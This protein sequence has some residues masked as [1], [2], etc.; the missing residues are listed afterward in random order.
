MTG[1]WICL[2]YLTVTVTFCKACLCFSFLHHQFY[3]LMYVK[4]FTWMNEIQYS[5]ENQYG[6][7]ERGKDLAGHFSTFK[8]FWNVLRSFFNRLRRRKYFYRVWHTNKN[9][10]WCVFN[11]YVT[12]ST[13]IYFEIRLGVK[14][15]VADIINIKSASMDLVLLFLFIADFEQI[16]HVAYSWPC[17]TSVTDL[18]LLQ[19]PR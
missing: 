16:L 5:K 15:G 18:G 8:I 12:Q 4:G 7:A 17:Q 1:F 14:K 13:C 11:L 10:L 3:T 6:K 19:H 2:L 9:K